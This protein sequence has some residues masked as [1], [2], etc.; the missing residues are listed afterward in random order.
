MSKRKPTYSPQLRPTNNSSDTRSGLKNPRIPRQT[1][2]SVQNVPDI[3]TPAGT[4]MVNEEFRRLRDGLNKANA[5]V[6]ASAGGGVGGAGAKVGSSGNTASPNSG[7]TAGTA[8]TAGAAGKNGKDGTIFP[9]AFTI[10][11][12]DGSIGLPKL[13]QVLNF[14]DPGSK[15]FKRPNYEPLRTLAVNSYPVVWE[16]RTEPGEEAYV[17]SPD[18]RKISV[19]G[20]LELPNFDRYLMISQIWTPFSVA[21]QY[22]GGVDTENAYL[23]HSDGT[24]HLSLYLR[25][26][27]SLEKIRKNDP[28]YIW[29]Y[30]QWDGSPN[31]DQ[32]AGDPVKWSGYGWRRIKNPSAV[33]PPS[34]PDMHYI[35]TQTTPATIWNIAHNMNKQVFVSI[36]DENNFERHATI[37][38][39]N[40]NFIRLYFA[41]A[42]TGT[43]E[44]H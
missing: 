1:V 2:I 32:I 22:G 23:G 7:G 6:Q 35:H 8:G 3:S 29:V 44:L 12:N 24:H 17:T 20:Y 28:D 43:A 27:L 42:S 38:H 40:D 15:K 5:A 11:E 31:A 19:G 10:E 41:V 26:D 18:K 33:V 21:A 16:F 4:A 9:W 14:L 34:T 30:S 37:E 36:R 13:V 39:V 25:G